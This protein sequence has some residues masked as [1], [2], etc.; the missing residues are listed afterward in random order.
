M[1]PRELTA[2]EIAAY[3]EERR[4]IPEDTLRKLSRD[5][6]ASVRRLAA[7]YLAA[8]AAAR[9]EALRLRALYREERRRAREGLVIAGVDEV[10]RGPLAGPVV[11]A[12]VVLP[13]GPP[14]PGLDDSKRLRS[15]Q[16]EQLDREIRVRALAVAVGEAS[17]EEIDRF[18]ILGATRLAMRRAVDSLAP[19]PHFLLIDGRE[20][21]PGPQQ[22][23]TVVRGD[24]SCACIAAASIIA[25]VARDR[26]M[27][28]LHETF[29]QYG[30]ARH[31]GYATVEHFAALAQFGPCPAHRRAFLPQHQ[32]ALFEIR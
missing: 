20:R 32:L 1:N 4:R 30:F 28:G 13:P 21:L 6:R 29:P 25:K 27:I 15:N 9:A 14:I 8:R 7:R 12:A 16:R 31:K 19:E 11:A 2:T 3:L 17:V 18:N 10:G 23:A 26:L 24:A 5:P 22:Q